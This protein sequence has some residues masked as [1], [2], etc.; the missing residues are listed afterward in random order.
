MAKYLG[1]FVVTSQSNF[2]WEKHIDISVKANRVLS[3]LRKYPKVV[4][5]KIKKLSQDNDLSHH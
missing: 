3:F 2:G 4:A 5:I 1:P